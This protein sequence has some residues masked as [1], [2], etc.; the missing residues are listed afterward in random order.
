MW[1]RK[2]HNQPSGWECDSGVDDD[3]ACDTSEDGFGGTRARA[4]ALY[5]DIH[6]GG[7]PRPHL[8]ARQWRGQRLG[9]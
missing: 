7:N 4:L 2:R 5:G 8:L 1:L 6:G 9:G 3:H